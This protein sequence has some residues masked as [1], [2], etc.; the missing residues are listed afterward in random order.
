MIQLLAALFIPLAL[1]LSAVPA[2]AHGCHQGWQ[3]SAEGVHRHGP[4][5]ERR[6][7]VTERRKQRAKQR[8]T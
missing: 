1:A 4:K 6:E 2:S 5:C 3:Q 7:G 8:S